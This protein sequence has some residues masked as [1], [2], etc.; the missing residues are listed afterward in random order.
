ML[1]FTTS[2]KKLPKTFEISSRKN[3]SLSFRGPNLNSK[4]SLP[5]LNE[6]KKPDGSGE[7]C[8][9]SIDL[10][11]ASRR[12]IKRSNAAFFCSSCKAR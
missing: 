10:W 9:A 1:G 5:L 2:G 3:S 4:A 7:V 6:S 8:I 12:G 11:Q